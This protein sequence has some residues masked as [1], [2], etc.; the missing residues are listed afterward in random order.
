MDKSF[1]ERSFKFSYWIMLIFLLADTIDTIYRTISGYLGEGSTIPGVDVLFKPTTTDMIVFVFFQ[2]GVI[3]GIYLLYKL[4]KVGAY[5]FLGSNVL[6][7][8]YAS[9]LGPIAQIGFTT[10]LPMFIFYFGIYIILVLG[11]PN[12][13]S[14]KF[15]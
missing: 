6:F 11:V 14:N 1:K 13:Y 4:K 12:Y 10:I 5:W 2:I 7:L 9:L 15:E 3:Y 8:I